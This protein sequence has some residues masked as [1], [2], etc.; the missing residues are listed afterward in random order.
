[1]E[2]KHNGRE[3]ATKKTN[4]GNRKYHIMLGIPIKELETQISTVCHVFHS[5]KARSQ[6]NWIEL[7]SRGHD[8]KHYQ[9]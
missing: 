5:V 4:G 1:M 3:E 9:K 8:V 6:C 7:R 2:Y